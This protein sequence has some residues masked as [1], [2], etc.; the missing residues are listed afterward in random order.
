MTR[1]GCTALLGINSDDLSILLA[2]PF[3][4]HLSPLPFQ[5]HR[6]IEAELDALEASAAS[7]ADALLASEQ[8]AGSSS[9]GGGGGAQGGG[10]DEAAMSRFDGRFTFLWGIYQAHS[11]LE[12]EI[13]F[14]ALE[15]REA[16]HNVTHSYELDHEQEEELFRVINDLLAAMRP[17]LLRA[18]PSAA[19]PRGEAGVALAHAASAG[20]QRAGTL[21]SEAAVAGPSTAEAK[22]KKW[23]S[24]L[25]FLSC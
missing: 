22:V 17:L 5:F 23:L 3:P 14:P 2:S 10:E 12:D 21:S 24:H 4:F 13:V 9:G 25:L 1:H 7:L 6:A 20:L 15:A 8:A 11:R 16:L 19:A 18:S